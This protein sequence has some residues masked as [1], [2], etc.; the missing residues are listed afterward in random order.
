MQA[1]TSQS[2]LIVVDHDL[3]AR[4]S[5]Q[6]KNAASNSGT[7]GGVA[8][9]YRNL[10]VDAIRWSAGWDYRDNVKPGWRRGSLGG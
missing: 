9:L 3:W 8:G 4:L 2:D 5:Q 6:L 7:R 10:G 1:H